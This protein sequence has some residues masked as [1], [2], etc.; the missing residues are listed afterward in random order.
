MAKQQKE[1]DRSWIALGAAVQF[2]T[3]GERKGRRAR[4]Q[5]GEVTRLYG[6]QA[7][8]SYKDG[9]GNP[10]HRVVHQDRLMLPA[11]PA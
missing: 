5:N 8:V 7:I 11:V 9:F 4:T 10:C 3:D 6:D 1:E 2:V